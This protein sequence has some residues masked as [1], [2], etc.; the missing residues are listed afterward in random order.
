MTYHLDEGDKKKEYI[1]KGKERFQKLHKLT[2]GLQ[3]EDDDDYMN[4]NGAHLSDLALQKRALS[5]LENLSRVI[6]CADKNKNLE[7]YQK[8]SLK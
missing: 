1:E 3:I 7:K 8:K 6:L 2:T 4:S 5:Q